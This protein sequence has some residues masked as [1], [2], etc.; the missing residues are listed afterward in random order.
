MWKHQAIIIQKKNNDNN[1]DDF[2]GNLND[3]I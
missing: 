1:D 3:S 2:N